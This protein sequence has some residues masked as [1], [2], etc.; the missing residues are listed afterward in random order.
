[1]VEHVDWTSNANSVAVFDFG[2][3]G[4]RP[5][6]IACGSGSVDASLECYIEQ[7]LKLF[8]GR[9]CAY[10]GLDCSYNIWVAAITF[11]LVRIQNL[12]LVIPVSFHLVS[13]CRVVLRL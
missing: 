3:T 8:L 13:R 1:M 5:R 10:N 2:V 6:K 11:A 4:K 7:F 12:V 9:C